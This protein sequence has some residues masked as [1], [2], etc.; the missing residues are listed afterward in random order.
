MKRAVKY[1]A[2]L[3]AA[4]LL[5]GCASTEE[6]PVFAI[7]ST[8]KEMIATASA[9][10]P[11]R[12]YRFYPGDEVSITAVNRPELNVSAKVDPL[13]YIA[14]PYVGQILVR[15]LTPVELADRLT[16]ALQ[17]GG[18]YVRPLITVSL[19]GTKDQFVY[20]LGEV[21]KPG[22][23]SVSGNVSLL[24]AI[25]RAGGQTYN[26]EMSTVLWIRGKQSPPGV[27]KLNLSDLGDPRKYDPRLPN[28]VM[29]PGD[30]LYVPDSVIASVERFFKR[31]GSII[32][33]IVDLERGLVLWPEV[34][35]FLNNS[36]T[37]QQPIVVK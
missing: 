25:G 28:L 5:A 3:L 33:P 24:E 19:M 35:A 34:E 32:G 29:I 37:S 13:G 17:D 4:A 20:V 10:A 36:S 7:S 16:R 31:L 14:Y 9:D 15:D 12:T 21:N 8:G 6:E 27:V 18:F 1:M 11:A 30:V 22:Q 23:I 2:G 26:S